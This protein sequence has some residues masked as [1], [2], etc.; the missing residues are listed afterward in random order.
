M[1]GGYG[2]HAI[3]D[4]AVRAAESVRQGVEHE[5]GHPVS[6]YEVLEAHSQ[7]VAGTNYKLKVRVSDTECVHLQV[8]VPLPHLRMLPRLKAF[9]AGHSITSP[10]D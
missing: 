6:V 4:S 2:P 10:L 8:Y 3:D 5:L 7:V 1:E 9:E